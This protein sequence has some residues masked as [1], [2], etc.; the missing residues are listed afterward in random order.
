MAMRN[1]PEQTIFDSGKKRTISAS[2]GLGLL[3]NGIRA[4]Y[5]T[6]RG[7]DVDTSLEFLH[8]QPTRSLN[9]HNT[10]N[11]LQPLIRTALARESVSNKE[12]T[13]EKAKG[14]LL[15]SDEYDTNDTVNQ[16]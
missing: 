4:S 8:P 14:W 7:I 13:R 12:R 2:G 6:V 15:F 16:A 5:Q 1:G 3:Q 11:Y 10:P 9:V